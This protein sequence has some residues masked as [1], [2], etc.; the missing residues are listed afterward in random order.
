MRVVFCGT[1]EFGIPTLRR[2]LADPRFQILGVITQPDRPRGRG[3]AAGE[4]PVKQLARTAGLEVFQP[5]KIGAPDA[6]VWLASKSLD[7]VVLIAYGQILPAR[8]LSIPRLGWINLHASLLPKYRGAAP[9]AWAIANG[10]SHTG[11]CTMQIDPGMDTGA[12]LLRREME[13]APDETAPQLS[14][15]MAEAGAPLVLETLER[16][17]RGTL[18]GEPQDNSLASYAPLLKREDGRI[19][20]TMPAHQI[21]NRCRGFDPWP[22]TFAE[23]RGARLRLWGRPARRELAPAEPVPAGSIRNISAALLVACGESTWLEITEVQPEGR[24]R[25]TAAEFVA[26]ARLAPNERLE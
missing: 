17:E 2:L 5:E 8:L 19:R 6:Q 24:R 7:V 18:R 26:G 12:V 1:P 10:E 20:W 3:M 16:L 15:R 4:S 9:I 23:F 14:A 11:I 22:G 13:I 25:M 21:Y